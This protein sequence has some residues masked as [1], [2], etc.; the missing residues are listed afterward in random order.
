MLVVLLAL[1]VS[2]ASYRFV[3]N[4]TRRWAVLTRNHW[5]TLAGAAALVVTCV[6]VN[7]AF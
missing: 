5:L 3:E 2:A 6:L 4:P 1:G 7:F